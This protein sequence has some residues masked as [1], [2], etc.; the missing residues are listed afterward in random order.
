MAKQTIKQKE[1]LGRKAQRVERNK[2][3]HD[4]Y[5]VSFSLITVEKTETPEQSPEQ[6]GILIGLNPV[7]Y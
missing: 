2:A 4:Y 5:L 7:I 6:L 3:L 1:S